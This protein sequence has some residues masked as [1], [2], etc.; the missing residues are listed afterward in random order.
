MF[1]FL[2]NPTPPPAS[3]FSYHQI[4]VSF[5]FPLRCSILSAVTRRKPPPLARQSIL[6]N[7]ARVFHISFLPAGLYL[8]RLCRSFVVGTLN[9]LFHRQLT[10]IFFVFSFSRRFIIRPLQSAGAV[11]FFLSAISPFVRFCAL[12]SG[13]S[14][15]IFRHLYLDS[16]SVFFLFLSAI[17]VQS[18][19]FHIISYAL[20]V[21]SVPCAAFVSCGPLSFP[22]AAPSISNTRLTY[23]TS[24]FSLTRF[25]RRFAFSFS[26]SR[27]RASA[28][29]LIQPSRRNGR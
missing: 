18:L 11:T 14:S 21:S 16:L 15:C 10:P 17:A 12:S 9:S 7:H 2:I 4:R 29:F 1:S 25:P 19:G 8:P 20:R 23:I 3:F 27:N 28:N 26:T 5:T 6:F 24:L 13:Q 22:R